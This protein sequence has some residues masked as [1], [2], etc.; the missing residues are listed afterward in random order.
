MC[1]FSGETGDSPLLPTAERLYNTAMLIRTKVIATIG[2]ASGD[3]ETLR[4]LAQAGCD[5]FRINFSHGNQKQ[6]L[7]FLS[8]I[9]EV[10][11]EL[12]MPLAVMA[13]LCGPKIRVRPIESGMI[14]LEAGQELV[15]QREP[16]V[17]RSDR[18]STTLPE[19][20][21]EIQP[22]QRILMDDGRI[23]LE[24][25]DINGPESFR[26]R[27]V[28]GGTLSSGKGVNLPQT[29]L[30]L[31]ALTEKDRRDVKWIAQQDFDFV[32][33]SFVRTAEDVNTLR[34][35]LEEAGCEA[36]IV[37]KIEKPQAVNQIDSIIAAADAIMV[38]RGD[39]GVEMDLAAVPICQ[40]KIARLCQATSKPCIIA[41]QM[42]E[43]MINSAMP[44]RAEVSDVAN[45]VFDSADAVMLSGE[46]AVGKYPVQ[47]VATMNDIVAEVQSYQDDNVQISQIDGSPAPTAVALARAVHEIIATDNI[48]AVA[49][50][51]VSGSTARLFAKQ[52]LSSPIIGISPVL[53]TVRRMCMYYGIDPVLHE[54]M[55]THTRDALEIASR[56]AIDRGI[57][58]IGDKIVV[59]SGRPLGEPGQTTT[60][61]VH[62]V[63]ATQ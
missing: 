38:A 23:R 26:C 56:V 37:A 63:G 21:D 39:L 14:L 60:L 53:A 20:V 9:R 54:H 50:F 61:V 24:V 35:L 27:V 13:D 47:T 51:T 36:H 48:A 2:K 34:R 55:L 3:K 12:G 17:G 42:L 11:Q 22:G 41:T 29:E 57:A 19:L 16:V 45:A 30:T 31:S 44:T 62:T 59:V 28:G 33:I 4:S 8:N 49:V 46:T 7:Q 52:R 15:I 32:A 25:I 40:K 58:K 18:I 1:S 43:S 10:E 5:V 6:R